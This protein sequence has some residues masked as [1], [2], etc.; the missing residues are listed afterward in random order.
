MRAVLQIMILKL[1]ILYAN[2][3]KRDILRKYYSNINLTLKIFLK[4]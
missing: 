4:Y 2:G 1:N 3:K